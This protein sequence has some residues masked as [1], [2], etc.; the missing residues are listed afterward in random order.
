MFW[1]RETLVSGALGSAVTWVSGYFGFG[2]N[3][4]CVLVLFSYIQLF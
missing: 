3:L 1:F 2:A 4:P